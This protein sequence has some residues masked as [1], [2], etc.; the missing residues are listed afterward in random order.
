[1]LPARIRAAGMSIS[2]ALTVSIFGGTT[3]FVATWLLKATGNALSPAWYVGALGI[4][5][6][7]AVLSVKE[8]APGH[9]PS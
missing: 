2:Y 9:L 8:T 6:A 5:S 3:Q 1:M 7:L 4:V